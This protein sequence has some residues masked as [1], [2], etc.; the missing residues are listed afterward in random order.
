MELGLEETLLDRVVNMS[1][2]ID[3][4][5]LFPSCVTVLLEVMFLL[6]FYDKQSNGHVRGKMA[7]GMY[8]SLYIYIYCE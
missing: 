5:F 1:A 4:S 6:L 8:S 2:V 3:F 7:H